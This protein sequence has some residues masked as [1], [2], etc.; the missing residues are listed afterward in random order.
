MQ[1]DH[2]CIIGLYYDIDGAGSLINYNML[3]KRVSDDA[4]LEKIC[5]LDPI[6]YTIYHNY[7][8]YKMSD[9]FDNRKS[10]NLLKFDFCPYC[11]CEIDWYGMRERAKCM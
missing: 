7:K 6:Y 10:T 9:Y 4:E 1:L 8:H 11:G 5:K 3:E 2:E